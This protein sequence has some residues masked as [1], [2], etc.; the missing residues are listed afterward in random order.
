MSLNAKAFG[1][2]IKNIT[3]W[4]NVSLLGFQHLLNLQHS[5]NIC[6]LDLIG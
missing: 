2:A 5:Y 4:F 6:L 3:I 1:L